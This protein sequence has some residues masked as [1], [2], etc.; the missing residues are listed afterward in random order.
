[1]LRLKKNACHAYLCFA[2]FLFYFCS[3]KLTIS[4][5]S[6]YPCCKIFCLICSFI[7]NFLL[8]FL[9]A[10][11]SSSPYLNITR[12]HVGA[13]FLLQTG[14]ARFGLAE[15]LAVASAKWYRNNFVFCLQMLS[16]ERHV[17]LHSSGKIV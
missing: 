11:L 1:M 6:T 10:N 3:L 17:T 8:L 14:L 12:F 4:F 2:G 15:F 13:I 7:N 5:L 9:I 16:L